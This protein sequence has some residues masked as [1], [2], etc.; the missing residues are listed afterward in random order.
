MGE[1]L[2]ELFNQG[3]D[4]I[5]KAAQSPLRLASLGILV[6]GALGFLLLR[7]AT[8]KLKLFKLESGFPRRILGGLIRPGISFSTASPR[9]P[10]RE[11][12]TAG[13][14]TSLL[15]IRWPARLG[16]SCISRRLHHQVTDTMRIGDF[17]C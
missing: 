5:G 2:N 13:F 1:I 15:F 3:P 12:E 11:H 10:A 8:G 4:I 7:D 6:L 14:G 17:D 9:A 16:S